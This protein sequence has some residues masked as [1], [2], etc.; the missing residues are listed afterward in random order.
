MKIYLSR[1]HVWGE[2]HEVARAFE[3]NFIAPLGPHVDKFEQLVS[4]R[5]GGECTA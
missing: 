2:Q 3:S 5:M 1:P 4:E